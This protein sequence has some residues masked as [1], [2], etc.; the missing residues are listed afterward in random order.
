MR[1]GIL[2]LVESD[3][4]RYKRLEVLLDPDNGG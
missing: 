3:Y 4:P 1:A 2:T